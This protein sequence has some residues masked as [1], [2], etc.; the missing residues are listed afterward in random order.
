[1]WHQ[2]AI[3][4]HE[5]TTDLAFPSSKFRHASSGPWP[6]AAQSSGAPLGRPQPPSHPAGSM[7]T[8][9]SKVTVLI[10]PGLRDVVA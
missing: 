7:T 9:D 3:N 1:M 6:D 2:L 4:R 5:L 8:Q 10:V